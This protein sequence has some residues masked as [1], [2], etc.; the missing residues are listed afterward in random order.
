[1]TNPQK[2]DGP[3]APSRVLESL[4]KVKG[5]GRQYPHT[6]DLDLGPGSGLRKSLWR[7]P[8]PTTVCKQNVH[9][10]PVTIPFHF[11]LDQSA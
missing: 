1:M 5:Q 2:K 11:G 6:A 3:A 8:S 9:P 7:Q 10:Q 4:S